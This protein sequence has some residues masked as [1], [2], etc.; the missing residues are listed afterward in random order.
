MKSQ[1]LAAI[2]LMYK[3][4]EVCVRVNGTKTKP[5]NVNFVQ[6]G[7]VLSPFLFMHGQ[8]RKR[9]FL[10][11]CRYIWECNVWRLLFADN[12]ALLSANKSDLQYS[13]DW[14]SDACLDAEMKISTAKSEI[15]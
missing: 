12:L 5:F 7:C 14:F 1:L 6:Q 10:L 4:T 11:Y 2:K 8:E 13:F 9:Q 3:Q 15:L